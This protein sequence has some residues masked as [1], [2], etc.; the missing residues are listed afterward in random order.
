MTIEVTTE[1]GSVYRIDYT[2]KTWERVEE[3]PKSGKVRT[4]SGTWTEV[5][6]VEGFPMLIEG[7]PLDLSRRKRQITT[8]VV[9]SVKE[10]E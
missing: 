5:I 1:N 6:F 8:S 3:S 10:V 9:T 7:P 4:E 2:T